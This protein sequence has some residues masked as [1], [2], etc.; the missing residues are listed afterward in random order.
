[1]VQAKN[2]ILT[3]VGISPRQLNLRTDV[4]VQRLTLKLTNTGS[5][6]LTFKAVHR[7]AMGLSLG[8]SWYKDAYDVAAPTAEVSV[9]PD[10]VTVAAG[11]TASVMVR[12]VYCLSACCPQQSWQGPVSSAC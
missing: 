6:A 7:P 10:V 3:T 9:T 8:L 5:T 12:R 1:M 4:T 2:A 11:G